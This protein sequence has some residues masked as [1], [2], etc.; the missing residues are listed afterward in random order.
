MRHSLRPCVID[1]FSGA[2]GLSLGAELAGFRTALCIEYDA[3]L[4]YS[5]RANFPQAQLL[6]AD[7][8]A[9]DPAE[10]MGHPSVV[11]GEIAGIVGG[12]P[13]QGFSVIG[14]REPNDPRNGMVSHFFR[15]VRAIKPPFFLFE[16][17][18]G[19]LDGRF[20]EYLSATLD[21]LRGYEIVGPVVVKAADFGAPT[22]RER[23]VIVGVHRSCEIARIRDVDLQGKVTQ[24]PTVAA[25]FEGLPSVHLALREDSGEHWSQYQQSSSN[26]GD[27]A[28]WARQK[29]RPFLSS[30]AIR[31][32]HRDGW[33]SGFQ[34]TEHAPRI[35]KRFSHVDPGRRDPVSR[36]PRLR[37]D[38]QSP[39]LRAGTGK[40]KGRFQ[41]ARPIH[42]EEDRVITVREAARIQ[43]FPDWFQFHPTKWHSFR[44]IGNSVSP[45]VAEGVL[46]VL[47]RKLL[48]G[49]S[50]ETISPN[51][52]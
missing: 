45:R 25:A 47:R 18:P 38:G 7:I 32:R 20:S 50:Q 23:V 11:S 1:L 36:Y 35:R 15:F 29:P 34:P 51:S 5:H 22:T 46:S 2:G 52:G 27:F 41:A 4:A 10:V 14:N 17:V 37:W 28:R 42:P 33:V 26:L 21:E 39:T 24:P 9:L 44:M 3:D 6:R 13:C 30:G 48:L 8:S 31:R 49:S 12:P 19:I 40:D 16:N 43:G